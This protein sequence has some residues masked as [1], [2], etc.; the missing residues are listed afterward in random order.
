MYFDPS[1]NFAISTFL[2]MVGVGLLAGGTIGGI[3]AG[4]NGTNVLEGIGKGMLAGGGLAASIGLTVA[5]ISFGIG[6]IGGSRMFSYGLS[7]TANMLE[8]AV[9]QGKKSH[10]DG[11]NFGARMNDVVMQCLL[12]PEK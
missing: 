2:I 6:T 12:I 10:Y 11:D 1:G 5:G 4:I 7:V 8:V 3:S 9:T